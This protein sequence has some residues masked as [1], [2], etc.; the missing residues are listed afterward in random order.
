MSDHW[1]GPEAFEYWTVS[2]YDSLYHNWWR[3]LTRILQPEPQPTAGQLLPHD[4]RSRNWPPEAPALDPHPDHGGGS[5]CARPPL[6][7][8]RPS[9]LTTRPPCDTRSPCVRATARVP[10]GGTT[11]SS[12]TAR[13]ASRGAGATLT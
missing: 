6:R 3:R 1:T 11:S 12:R 4:G 5:R 10:A 8:D 2:H 9:A 7:T 13:R